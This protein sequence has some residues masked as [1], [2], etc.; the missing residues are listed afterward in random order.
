MINYENRHF[1]IFQQGIGRGD[2]MS[3]K[4]LRFMKSYALITVIAAVLDYFWI[5]FP[6][7]N[8]YAPLITLLPLA[9]PMLLLPIIFYLDYT[10]ALYLFSVRYALSARVQRR[11]LAYGALIGFASALIFHGS[12]YLFS[13][14][15]PPHVFAV[16]VLWRAVA[17]AMACGIFYYIEVPEEG[18]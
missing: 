11:A 4:L 16:D 18:K 5:K 9:L 14:R 8:L 1:Y 6:A 17:G 7:R 10:L 2:T 13:L 3:S 12:A 15:Y